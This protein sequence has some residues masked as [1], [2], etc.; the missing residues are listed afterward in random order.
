MELRRREFIINKSENSP[1]EC[2]DCYAIAPD[3][4]RIAVS[5]GAAQS[6]FTGEWAEILTFG[7]VESS[8]GIK[9]IKPGD[10][11]VRDQAVKEWLFEQWLPALQAKWRER[12]A[13]IPVPYFAEERFRRGAYA[14][15]LGLEFKETRSGRFLRWQ[16]TAV[17]D[18]MLFIVRKDVLSLWFPFQLKD[19]GDFPRHPALLCSRILGNDH[20][21]NGE[22]LNGVLIAGGKCSPGDVFILG[23]DALA[24]WFLTRNKAGDRPWEKLC[25]ITSQEEFAKFVEERRAED[26]IEDDDTTL[27]IVDVTQNSPILPGATGAGHGD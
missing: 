14:T 7:F 3:K 11:V 23:T 18:S 5:D 9:F 19:T 16:A 25:A 24:K 13:G 21:K 22:G 4:S 1:N 17:G 20:I 10:K 27:V 15:F 2:K 26:Q 12:V 6:I 8:P